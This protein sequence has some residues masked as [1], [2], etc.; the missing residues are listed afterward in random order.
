MRAAAL[1]A[2][3]AL[4]LAA[5]LYG[6]AVRTVTLDEAVA[7][8]VRSQPAMVAARQDVRV[9]EAQQRQAFGAWL[10]TLSF[11]S[12]TQKSGATRLNTN[13]GQP[14]QFPSLYSSSFGFNTSWDVF[15]GFRR[16]AVRR[17]SEA[18][19]ALADATLLRQEYA[20]ALAT[21]QTFFQT[22]AFSELVRVQE[23]RL[24]SAD[25]QLK[26]TSER[27]RLGA[28]TRSDSLRARVEYGQAQLALIE[29]QNNLRTAQANLGRAIQIEGLVMG[30]YDSTL[31]ARP[32]SIDTAA[33]RR[34]A[35]ATAPSIRQA[36]ASVVS[37]RAAT[38]AARSSYWPTAT[39]SGGWS[40]I[41]AD[42]VPYGGRYLESWNFR[43]GLTLPI[44]NGFTRETNV[45]SADANYR[46]AAA[47]ERDAHLELDALLTQNFY[48]LEA[49]AARID[50]SRVSVTAAQEDLR[51]QRERYRL[52]AV[53]IIEVL[54]SQGNLDQA[55]V[56][57]VQARY[58][59]L[60]ARAS[61]E[62]L[63]GH[64]L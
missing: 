29:A 57:L 20:T 46:D 13:T 32:A 34:D 28:T 36:E 63:V 12:N 50:V 30:V 26:L 48:D 7:L 10:P 14:Q 15:T 61:I 51:M 52:G 42:S 8:S 2:V 35:R 23:T 16:G 37:T 40:K 44:F 4:A 49:A 60:V 6:Q 39:L 24:R 58:D 45:I 38:S 17:Q 43:L 27:L 53:T 31:E 18:N 62:A 33:L 3:T 9:A 22:L 55:E 41:G 11:S 19:T 1:A 21:K 54:A 64:S 47:R 5:P 56:D 59:Y 25:E